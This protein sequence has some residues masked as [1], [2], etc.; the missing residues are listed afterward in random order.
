MSF[1]EIKEW[2]I[3]GFITPEPVIITEFSSYRWSAVL[4]FL[5]YW[6]FC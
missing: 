5:L 4:G 3:A 6:G 2:K 1:K